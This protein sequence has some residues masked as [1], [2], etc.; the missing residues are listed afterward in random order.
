M[1]H[2]IPVKTSLFLVEGIIENETGIFGVRPGGSGLA[3][4][5]GPVRSAVPDP[6]AESRRLPPFSGFLGKTA[7]VTEGLDQRSW[8]IVAA[9]IVVSLMTLVSMLKIWSGAFWGAPDEAYVPGGN[10]GILRRHPLMAGVTTAVVTLTLL[11]AVFAGPL[12]RFCERAA[13]DVTDAT[14]YPA[15]VLP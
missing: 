10:A 7:V 12:Y 11:I 14:S 2:H 13:I 4:R 6:R 15:A 3:R 1:L 5:S 8:W 9:A